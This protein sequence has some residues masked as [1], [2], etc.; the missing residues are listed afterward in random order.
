MSLRPIF[1]SQ[2]F[3]PRLA[4]VL[5]VLYAFHGLGQRVNYAHQPHLGLFTEPEPD[6]FFA[7]DVITRH[8][9]RFPDDL[10]YCLAE[11]KVA[12]AREVLEWEQGQCPGTFMHEVRAQL[13]E[14]RAAA[15]HGPT[16]E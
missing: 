1:S 9:Y 3:G 5:D 10:G 7:A 11:N 2:C 4:A 12:R 6:S 14:R 13:K 8:F 16:E 15:A